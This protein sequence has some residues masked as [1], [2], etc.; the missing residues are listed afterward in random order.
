ML[1]AVL[2]QP[3]A[4]WYMRIT[5]KGDDQQR[6]A[7][8]REFMFQGLKKGLPLRLVFELLTALLHIAVFLSLAGFIITYIYL[9]S[10]ALSLSPWL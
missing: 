5:Q 7:R 10:I 8:I 2:L 3:W 4:R 6:R 9:P 1:L